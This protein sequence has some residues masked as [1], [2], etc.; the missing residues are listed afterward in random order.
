[1]SGSASA[2]PRADP[3]P[4]GLR[5]GF[6]G[7]FALSAILVLLIT[8]FSIFELRRA[9]RLE[10]K[11]IQHDQLFQALGQLG[12]AFERKSAMLRGYLLTGDAKYLEGSIAAR[13]DFLQGVDWVEGVT[14]D[15]VA[16]RLI[17]RLRTS[18]AAHQR[19]WSRQLET[20]TA[21]PPADADRILALIAGPRDA[22][23][24]DVREVTEYETRQMEQEH[25]SEERRFFRTALIVLTSGGAALLLTLV[26]TG[27]LARRLTS[28][29]E[30]EQ[31]ARRR[32]EETAAALERQGR[33]LRAIFEGSLDPMIIADDEGRLVDVNPAAADL[34]GVPRERLTGRS[35]GE[36]A[37]TDYPFEETWK[38]FREVG[39]ARGEFR[40]RRADGSLRETEFAATA[41][42]RPGRHLSALRDVTERKQAEEALR[43]S[44]SRTRTILASAL[45]A[46]ITI[47]DSGRV[48][49]FNPAA[50][51]VFGYSHAE[52][53][54]REMAEL[55]I[56]PALRQSHRDGMRRYLAG[57]EGPVLG[58]R[59]EM[60]AMRRDGTEFPVELSILRLPGEG[61]PVFT[62]FLRDIT[63]QQQ[64][65][66][67][68]A[69]L[70]ALE[71][72]ARAAAEQS[73]S[74]SAFLVEASTLLASSMDWETT[75]KRVSRLSVPR[76]ADWCVVDILE[77]GALEPLAVSHVD[78]S[79][80]ELV[81]EIWRRF[82]RDQ[83]AEAG[84]AR[85]ARTGRSELSEQIS[86]ELLRR[87]SRS[88]EHYELVRR[89]RLGSSVC[90]PLEVR[91]QILGTLTFAYEA[92]GRR[93][94]PDDVAFAES[95]ASRASL[96]IDNAR[97]FRQ[98]HDA[99]RLRDEFLSIA[100]H[101]LK[102]PITTLKLQAQ[103]LL[104]RS[105]PDADAAAPR[106]LTLQRQ[107]ER[108]HNLVDKLLDISRLTAGRLELELEPVDLEALVAEVMDRFEEELRR[109]GCEVVVRGEG[110]SLGRWD[111]SRLD[112]VVTNLISNAIKYGS[113]KPILVTMDGDERTARLE[114]RDHGIGIAPENL[115]R[116][117][118]RFE[119][120]VSER[121]YGGLG[122]GLWIVS[123]IVDALGGSVHATSTPGE[124]AAFV[125]ELPRE[126]PAAS[127][128]DS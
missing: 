109:T 7:G 126:P 98:A 36:F 60:P 66:A 69:N 103:S 61:R 28:L 99:I 93:Y 51:R 20:L 54:G 64:A 113:G 84:P 15:P 4:R 122:L 106:L 6:V 10:Q 49:E 125:V 47:D 58:R 112:Q 26:L 33:E 119:R 31:G 17:A 32:A 91:G 85:V 44:E 80:V 120:A 110:S 127:S 2:S 67:G 89:L 102:T 57:G 81:Y 16:D 77:D 5:R 1:M 48:L 71:R 72:K 82:P 79:Q 65:E 73:E 24:R 40:L 121:H 38:G 23:A 70:L 75:L 96:A 27:M 83:H 62:G 25:R 107:I 35:I 68:R 52:A 3:A 86:D 74:K 50:E 11:G 14:T 46:I 53:L 12:A 116:I 29:Y 114:V 111:R 117:F 19:E 108:L 78:Q 9:Q 13:K 97:L 43:D 39:S 21:F 45:D 8:G 22:L 123:E 59:L 115:G 41:D 18:E 55:I 101:E 105:G 100:S 87:V 63:Q 94:G 76:I 37:E 104:R 88:E 118:Q 34:F 30:Q 42:V 95:L 56:P 124:G 92:G 128:K 90:V